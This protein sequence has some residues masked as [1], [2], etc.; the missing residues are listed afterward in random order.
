MDLLH[1]LAN[2]G[3]LLDGNIDVGLGIRS[4]V[5]RRRTHSMP[6]QQLPAAICRSAKR[7]TP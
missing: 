1:H 4:L 5:A 6:R 3:P 2:F 7:S